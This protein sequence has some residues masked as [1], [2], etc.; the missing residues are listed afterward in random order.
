MSWFWRLYTF[1]E[2]TFWYS[3]SRKLGSLF[4]I[5]VLQLGFM[6]IVWLAWQD[7]DAVLK[8]SGAD[9]SLAAQQAIRASFETALWRS[10]V[11]W[12]GSLVFIG[13]MVWYLRFLIVRPLK[14]II[15]IFNDIG[16]GEGDLSRSI[17][18]LTYDEIRQLS[19]SYNRFIKKIREIISQVR[20]MT[21]RIA[22]E[23]A[24]SQQNIGE[25]LSRASKQDELAQLVRSASDN[26][27]VGITAISGETQSIA[28]TTGANLEVARGARGELNDVAG[29][30]KDIN[31]RVERFNDTVGELNT[32][33][34]SIKEIVDLIKDISDQT[35]LLALNAAIEAARAGEAGRGFAVVAD[36]VRKLAE[37]VKGATDEISGNIDGMLTLVVETRQET[38][39]ITNDT[40]L[41]SG[42][43]DR[44]SQHFDN[45][46]S[47]FENTSQSLVGIAATVESF[48]TT[49]VAVN[50]DVS[51]IHRLSEQVRQ[52][53]AFSAQVSRDLSAATEQV[54]ELV[55]RFIIGEGEFDRAITRAKQYRE[56]F[57]SQLNAWAQAG[58]NVFD[59]SYRKIADSEPPRYRV[60]Y[61]ERFETDMQPF[62][63]QL[64]NETPGGR[65]SLLVDE[66]GYAPTHNSFYSKKP[67]GNMAEDLIGCRD[68]RIFNDPTG[69][70]AAKNLQP[71]L[72]QTYTRDTGEVLSEIAMPIMVG[73]RHWGALRLGFDASQMLAKR[74]S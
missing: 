52:K 19:E 3:L 72:L 37:R 33:S 27:T 42:V 62:Y 65:F 59:R 1:M 56:R 7:V 48:A 70:R 5:S 29:R 50:R 12:F 26:N 44:A 16:E 36:E 47:D 32:R 22:M 51:E 18:V 35:N 45:M 55:S 69:S 14:L 71:F 67:T 43:V 2:K 58:V 68:K 23:S 63:D 6:G 39:I 60:G 41:A 15:G 24:R 73:G 20:E 74:T 61:D 54:Q 49:N 25:S 10:G 38:N 46:V 13:L 17:P 53:L 11:L 4:F 9:V 64:V 28:G 40:K 34:A 66:N 21:V 57:E 31:G 30:I 8:A